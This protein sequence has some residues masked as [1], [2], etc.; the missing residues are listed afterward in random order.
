MSSPFPTRPE[1]P[2]GAAVPSAPPPRVAE[3]AGRDVPLWVPFATLAAVVVVIS[4][5]GI[6]VVS[7]AA[8]LDPSIR[9]SDPP[10]W[11]QFA[12]T[13]VQGGAFV[14][15]A[16]MAVRAVRPG[17]GRR[18]FGLVRPDWLAA[19]RWA[20]VLYAGFWIV[21]GVLVKVFGD[22]PEQDVVAQLRGQDAVG[23]LI[24][25]AA[26]TCVVAPLAEEFFF[27]GFVFAV[28]RRRMA[29]PWAVA[30]G[31]LVFGAVHATGAPSPAL[32]VV[33]LGVLGAALCLL[34][35]RT[36]SIV[37]GMALHAIHNSISFAVTKHFSI[38]GTVGLVL[39]CAGIV[40]AI[41][42]AVAR[43]APAP[44]R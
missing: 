36:G 28:F 30:L 23:E 25:F 24:L 43:P 16:V 27:R 22:P 40:V 1:L 6:A 42:T 10:S 2:E 37:P 20:A 7:L 38:A 32:V 26:V 4:L 12:L 14:V 3:S 18:D 41:A 31:G 5:F 29:L 34:Y 17:A 39:L 33:A 13:A 19:V 44:A 21:S 11:L 35:S 8:S 15:G 9:V